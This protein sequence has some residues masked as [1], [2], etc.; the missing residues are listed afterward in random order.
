MKLALALVLAVILGAVL[1]IAGIG[2]VYPPAALIASGL[3]LMI[4]AYYGLTR[5]IGATR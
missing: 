3:L 1:L 2:L 4:A 5:D